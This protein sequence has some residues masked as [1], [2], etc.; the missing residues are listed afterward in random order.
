MATSTRTTERASQTITK[1]KGGSREGRMGE[2]GG[3][4]RRR[5]WRGEEE[6]ER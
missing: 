5:R 6:G 4:E 1:Y 3:V 2:E